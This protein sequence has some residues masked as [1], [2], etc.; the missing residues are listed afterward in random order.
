M[1]LHMEFSGSPEVRADR[2]DVWRRVVDPHF[3]ARSAPGVQTVR[4]IGPDQ[5]R[6]ESM[7]GVGPI[8]LEFVIEIAISERVEPERARLRATASAHGATVGV[9]SAVRLEP[10]DVGR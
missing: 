9:M 7:I 4:E 10:L 2:P 3:V 5:Y 6:I 1:P 8:K